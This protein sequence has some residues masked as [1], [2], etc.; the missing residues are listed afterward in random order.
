MKPKIESALEM[1]KK[2]D[3]RRITVT[4]A[5]RTDDVVQAPSCGAESVGR[6]LSKPLPYGWYSKRVCKKPLK[7]VHAAAGK[8]GG[9]MFAVRGVDA[10]TVRMHETWMLRYYDK[11]RHWPSRNHA[12]RVSRVHGVSR[13]IALKN[14]CDRCEAE[15]VRDMPVVV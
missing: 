11:E 14:N 10:K 7:E 5:K 12:R 2:E 4:S 9:S 3:P 1:P 8:M 13:T 15:T 6:T